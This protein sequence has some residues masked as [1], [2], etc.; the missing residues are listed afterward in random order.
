MNIYIQCTL[1]HIIDSKTLNMVNS[2]KKKRL[3]KKKNT[4]FSKNEMFLVDTISELKEIPQK[5]INNYTP[6]EAL[7]INIGMFILKLGIDDV[8]KD[9]L[10]GK[11]IEIITEHGILKINT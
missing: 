8:K 7:F 10:P 9:N 5:E 2:P 6:D 4:S 3:T 1:Y 11:T